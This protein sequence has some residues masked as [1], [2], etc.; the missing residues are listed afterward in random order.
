L[1]AHFSTDR[2]RVEDLEQK[3]PATRSSTWHSALIE[4]P[5]KL[6]SILIQPFALQRRFPENP[7][8]LFLEVAG[9]A[10][11]MVK[12]NGGVPCDYSAY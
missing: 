6:A 3:P 4:L 5:A 10:T 1:D 7:A 12:N 11:A 9:L 2:E 8:Y